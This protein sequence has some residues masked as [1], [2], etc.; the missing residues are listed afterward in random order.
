MTYGGWPSISVVI[1]YV[2]ACIKL[3][4]F[5]SVQD[6][7]LSLYNKL[8]K[9]F[10]SDIFSDYTDSGK[11]MDFVVWPAL[12]LYD[13]GPILRKGVAQGTKTDTNHSK[14][15]VLAA[16]VSNE[17]NEIMPKPKTTFD[18]V[19]GTTQTGTNAVFD[20]VKDAKQIPN[21]TPL[22][23]VKD[24][25]QTAKIKAFD[26]GNNTTHMSMNINTSKNVTG[27]TQSL[28]VISGAS[29]KNTTWKE[30]E[31]EISLNTNIKDLLC[32]KNTKGKFPK[33]DVKA[34]NIANG[35]LHKNKNLFT[36]AEDS[37]EAIQMGVVETDATVETNKIEHLN[38]SSKTRST[39]R[40]IKTSKSVDAD[41]AQRQ[42]WNEARVLV[43]TKITL[44]DQAD[45]HDRDSTEIQDTSSWLNETK[46]A[47]ET[48]DMLKEDKFR[49]QE[50]V[51]GK[52]KPKQHTDHTFEKVKDS[53]NRMQLITKEPSDKAASYFGNDK[54][55][56]AGEARI[57]TISEKFSKTNQD[58][59]HSKKTAGNLF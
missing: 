35:T 7:P 59:K 44:K 39:N 32:N 6:P 36:T 30:S 5:M 13:G 3:C 17:I 57:E 27:A 54:K 52:D 56:A 29:K 48:N 21:T 22:E 14:V 28:N 47:F 26:G 31:M 25:V 53:S 42:H 50:N 45:R 1:S 51:N 15:T 12:Y 37:K 18:G 16:K 49:H 24:T 2:E 55:M 23:H 43:G 46:A 11:Y 4:W 38:E 9:V 8:S 19:G 41:L 58:S 33:I 20:E 34:F 40:T 10:D